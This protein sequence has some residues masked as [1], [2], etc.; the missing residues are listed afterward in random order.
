MHVQFRSKNDSRKLSSS[1][2]GSFFI[3]LTFLNY[4]SVFSRKWNHDWNCREKAEYFHAIM[5]L[6][7]RNVIMFYYRPDE[8][9]V[10]G[11]VVSGIAN[12]VYESQHEL[13]NDFRLRILGKK[14]IL[15]KS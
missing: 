7:F 13:R 2:I 3:E 14:E 6:L 10:K 1:L 9:Q 5:A 8:P 15:G 4:L 12:L 11:N